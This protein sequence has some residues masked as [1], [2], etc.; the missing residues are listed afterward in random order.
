L[1]F[2][3]KYP[4]YL[5]LL[6]F[7]IVGV[8]S[9]PAY[10]FAWDEYEQRHIGEVCYNYIF[11]GDLFYFEYNARDHGAIFE[12]FLFIIEKT[13]GITE[14]RDIYLMRH[15]ISH[16]FFLIGA[17]YFYKLIFLI[18]KNKVLSLLGFLLLVVHPTIY[19]HSFFNS[20]DIPFLS[21]FIIC[22]YQFTAAFR[23][24][25]LNQ[26]LFL[27][28]FTGLLINIRIMGI[29][30][31][32]FVIF[33]LCFDLFVLKKEKGSVKKH[34]LLIT[35]FLCSAALSTIATWPLL[36]QNPLDNFLY[37]FN[38]LSRYP[39][40]GTTLFN[41]ESINYQTMG[42][43]YIP[44]WFV[45]NTP[46]VYLVLGFS[47]IILFMIR[48]FKKLI[49][50]N[51]K[52]IDKNNLM[53]LLSFVV[54]IFTVIILHSVLYDTWRHLFYIYP[55]FILLAI[56]LL[57]ELTD[58]K[59]KVIIQSIALTSILSVSIFIV[60]NF[61]FHH[62][63]FNQFVSLHKGEYIR[64]NYEMDYWGVS[65]NKSLEYILANDQSDTIRISADNPTI[66]PNADMLPEHSKKRIL[67]VDS[68][69]KSNYFVAG[70]R[71]HP[72]DYFTEYPYIKELH[73]FEVL[74][75]KIT[76]IF[77]VDR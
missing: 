33:F 57:N 25:K 53:F 52:A 10:G 9:A 74:N 20:K 70:Y 49:T 22:F 55:A 12:L 8:I 66:I 16:L 76:T 17:L 11:S 77:K 28:L 65:L 27:G 59:F 32:V 54:P 6:L 41:G 63:Y 44:T 7:S 36:W 35:L 21:L 1:N 31:A 47:G 73:S 62:I 4:E 46:I 51:F 75:S 48:T 19:G 72:Q 42:W 2:V 58:T 69:Y 43:N 37:A 15:V 40:E 23:D 71:W 29:L 18:Y 5:L 30:F 64:N 68:V 67:F 14:N 13:I 3:K 34:L 50:L 24:K 26:I 39:W 61:P 56:Y 38:N 60:S 45:I